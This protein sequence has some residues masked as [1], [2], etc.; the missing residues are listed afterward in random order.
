M[1]S[2]IVDGSESKAENQMA[3]RERFLRRSNWSCASVYFLLKGAGDV[4]KFF[5]L[6]GCAGGGFG[7]GDQ[8]LLRSAGR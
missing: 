4:S 3:V 2:P 7:S 8:V 6:G 5:L 1:L